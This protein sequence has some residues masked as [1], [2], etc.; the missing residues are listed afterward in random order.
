MSVASL[1]LAWNEYRAVVESPFRR[2]LYLDQ[3]FPDELDEA[4]DSLV[5]AYESC[6]EEQRQEW[7]QGVSFVLAD[8]QILLTYAVR[9]ATSSLREGSI[10]PIRRG[11]IAIL[12][13]GER[14]DWREDVI[15]LSLLFDAAIKHL[16][17]PNELFSE[18]AALAPDV[19]SS[20]RIQRFPMRKPEN[21]SIESMGYQLAMT[22]KGIRYE[23]NKTVWNRE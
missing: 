2:S 3:D 9:M 14:N 23:P 22:G 1:K 13:E 10:E 8:S 18:I 16:I 4:I 21:R 11:L 20:D 15:V 19:P 12:V 7:T 17:D 5:L 6:D